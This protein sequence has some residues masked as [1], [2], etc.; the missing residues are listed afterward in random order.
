MAV[1]WCGSR[2]FVLHGAVSASLF[3][4]FLVFVRFRE[5]SWEAI[6]FSLPCSAPSFRC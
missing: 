3:V 1:D 4:T 6:N 2:K 5:H